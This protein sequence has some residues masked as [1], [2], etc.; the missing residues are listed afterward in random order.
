MRRKS[1]I[2]ASVLKPRSRGAFPCPSCGK[3]MW[4]Y[5]PPHKAVA[6]IEDQRF[7]CVTCDSEYGQEVRD[8]RLA[9]VR[10]TP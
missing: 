9:F 7:L 6:K 5:E 1:E 4:R 8:G 10:V 3:E 2:D